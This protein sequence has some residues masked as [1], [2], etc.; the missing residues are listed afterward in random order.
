M[1]GLSTVSGN[2]DCAK[3]MKLPGQHR[4][5]RERIQVREMEGFRTT[6]HYYFVDHRERKARPS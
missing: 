5:R 1:P 6:G 4:Y 2:I 3:H